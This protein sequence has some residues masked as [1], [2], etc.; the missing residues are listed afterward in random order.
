M[1]RLN[2]RADPLKTTLAAGMERLGRLKPNGALARYSPLSRFLEIDVLIMGI[3][4]KKQLWTTLRDAAD[5]GTR[6]REIDFDRL[7]ERAKHQRAML[8]PFHARTGGEALGD[9]GSGSR[10]A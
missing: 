7:V 10:N 4:G 1:R 8:E 3:D 2:V 9:G 5:L 6:L